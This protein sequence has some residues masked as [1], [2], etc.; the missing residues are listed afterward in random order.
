MSHFLS[1]NDLLIFIIKE[2]VRKLRKKMEI[3]ENVEK[4]YKSLIPWFFGIYDL[5]MKESDIWRNV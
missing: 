4:I 5:N 3:T 1:L 2:K